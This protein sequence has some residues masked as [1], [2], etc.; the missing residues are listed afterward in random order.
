M[1]A[2]D[3]VA[4]VL[5]EH[6]RREVPA[7]H[8]TCCECLTCRG[9][10]DPKGDDAVWCTP[11]HLAAMLAAAGLLAPSP[12]RTFRA[13]D[14]EPDDVRCVV[15]RS[16]DLW[17]RERGK[18]YEWPWFQAESEIGESWECVIGFH[19]LTEVRIPGAPS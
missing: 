12:P 16:G 13:G 1:S 3:R 6:E 17:V 18:N 2:E 14:P 5:D 19:P 9:G 10:W 4:E 11:E 15:D 7:P 8:C